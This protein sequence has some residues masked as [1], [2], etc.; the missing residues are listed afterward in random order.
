MKT[1]FSIYENLA[2]YFYSYRYNTMDEFTK[3]EINTIIYNLNRAQASFYS[4]YTQKMIELLKNFIKDDV[5][6]T[7]KIYEN[8]TGKDLIATAVVLKPTISTKEYDFLPAHLQLDYQFSNGSYKLTDFAKSVQNAE[9]VNGLS[10]VNGTSKRD[11]ELSNIIANEPL[12]AT[13]KTIADMYKD[14]GNTTS[15][16]LVVLLRNA[17]ADGWT[18][19]KFLKAVA[20]DKAI[21]FNDELFAR[22]YVQNFSLLNTVLQHASAIVQES[23]ASNYFS[24]YQW[25]SVLDNRTTEICI[26][27]NGTVYIFGKGPLP[28]A[29]F[30][31]RS[32]AV[33]TEKDQEVHDIPKSYYAWLKD[34]P[35]D[36]QNDILGATRAADLR[37]GKL[38]ADD[39]ASIVG[40]IK[41]ISLSEF[42][43]KLKYILGE[44]NLALK[45]KLTHTEFD[46][47]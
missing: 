11:D 47:L 21:N 7:T 26:A 12:P 32:K 22:Y 15:L 4:I 46:A 18:I 33:H 37:S 41:P 3:A 40:T 8:V 1:L 9:P 20:G 35:A 31:C 30:N 13:A 29:H 42:T 45:H 43:K 16:A 36:F 2:R 34:Q 23:V 27:R 38:G 25:V 19:N 14:F 10:I 39:F 6:V 24:Y 5:K 17:Y 28:P 44:Y